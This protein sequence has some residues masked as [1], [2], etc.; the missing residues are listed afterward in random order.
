MITLTLVN[1]LS[2]VTTKLYLVELVD[3]DGDRKIVKAFGL[4]SITG[5]LQ[6]I[7]YG[8]LKSEFSP[9]IQEKWTSLVSRPSGVVVDLLV[10]S[11]VINLHP[12]QL[13]TRGNMMA[14]RSRF[15]V[16]YL[17]NMTSPEITTSH[18]LHFAETAGAIRVGNFVCHMVNPLRHTQGR[19]VWGSEY[20]DKK[21]SPTPTGAKDPPLHQEREAEKSL[22][23][24]PRSKPALGRIGSNTPRMSRRPSKALRLLREPRTFPSIRNGRQ[25]RV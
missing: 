18:R 5:K 3:R 14:K 20:K 19:A 23:T 16:G 21:G 11:K 17:L 8:K 24:S 15:G 12:A 1:R 25:R 4:D 6:T 10:V 22:K 7:D 9:Q 2:D 13:E